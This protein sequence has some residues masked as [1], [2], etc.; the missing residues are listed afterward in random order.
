MGVLQRHQHRRRTAARKNFRFYARRPGNK[1]DNSESD[2]VKK[3]T[4]FM[5]REY[6]IES[7]LIFTASRNFCLF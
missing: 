2:R 3:G 1:S 4:D 5:D 7:R 6:P